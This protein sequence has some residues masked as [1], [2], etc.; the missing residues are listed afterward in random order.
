MSEKK[1]II[2]DEKLMSEW[3]YDKNNKLY[4]K[5]EILTIGSGQIVWWKCSKGHE[6]QSRISHRSNGVGCPYCS[7]RRIL[8]GYN[9]L[10]TV[11][12]KLTREWNY[13][14]N[15]NLKP[16]NFTKGSSKKVWW[17]C[18]KGHEW[19]STIAHRNDGRGCPICNLERNTSFPEY[20]IEYYLRKYGFETIHS[21]KNQGYELDIY[22]PS[23]KIA[24]EYDGYFWH[25]NKSQKDLE[26][27]FK[28]KQDGIKLYRIRE[29]LLSLNDTSIDYIIQ[30]DQKDLA[31]VLKNILRDIIETDID[32]NLPRDMI[33]I[34]NL[35]EYKEKENSFLISNPNA[36]KE[37]NYKKNKNLKPENFFANS[38]KKVWWI[39]KDGHEWQATISKRNK[40][41]GCPYCSGVKR[42]IGYNDLTTINP[43]LASEWNYEKNKNLKPEDYVI[44]SNK[45]VW[46]ICKNGHEWQATIVSRNAGHGCPYCVG[47]KVI[48]GYNDLTTINPIL[49]NEWNYKKNNELTPIDV[50]ANSN[51]KVWWMCSK[52]H[53]WQATINK[54]NHGRGCPFCANKKILQGY[55]DLI[56]INP[57]L[58]SEW[59]YKKNKNLKP[60][61]FTIGSSK[62]VWW[63]CS[64]GHEWEATIAH[65][66]HG[67]GCPFCY[68]IKR[69]K[70]DT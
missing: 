41:T 47:Q 37:W 16:E 23:K 33:D 1:Y 62:K 28:C 5:P 55:N 36:A 20:A 17:I 31:I 70:K 52:G 15:K 64:K 34:E 51:K 69:N 50:M 57:N 68:I 9:D 44:S 48:K 27:N 13:K 11:N 3:D 10:T 56:T 29:G 59:N 46:W 38:D 22:I 8:K 60:E 2:N 65:R 6:Y 4:L 12:P 63:K 42:M 14:K 18:A 49:A 43:N 19:K 39:C 25:K 24:I 21:Y 61:D 32:V 67:R 7:G 35:R 40:G 26:K 54:R 58:A 45:K 66:T 53:E 30:K